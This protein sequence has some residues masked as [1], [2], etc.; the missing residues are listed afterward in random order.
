MLWHLR[1][2]LALFSVETSTQSDLEGVT[3]S[4]DPQEE[5]LSA[6]SLLHEIQIGI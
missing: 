4:P 2:P 5:D 3:P 6:V 1:L